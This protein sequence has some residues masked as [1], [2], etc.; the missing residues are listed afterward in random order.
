[1][2]VSDQNIKSMVKALA[3]TDIIFTQKATFSGPLAN[4]EKKAPIIWKRG[5]PGGCP[6]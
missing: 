1:M 5:A 2:R 6:T 3:I 4:E